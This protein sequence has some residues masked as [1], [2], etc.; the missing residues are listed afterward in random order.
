MFPI[1]ATTTITTTAPTAVD[2]V[3]TP[4]VVPPQPNTAQPI[5][6]ISSP[7]HARRT[8]ASLS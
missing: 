5:Y 4:T 6:L 8:C 1:T 2:T 3:D 7:P